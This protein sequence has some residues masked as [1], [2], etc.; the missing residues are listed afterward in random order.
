MRARLCIIGLLSAGCATSRVPQQLRGYD[1][2]VEGKD[3]QS[4]ELARVM[5]GYGFRV[6][7]KV[8]GGGRPTAALIYFTFPAAPKQSNLLHVWLADTRSGA[9]IGAGSVVLDSLTATPRARAAAVI[10]AMIAP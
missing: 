6:R 8:R 1:V 7:D 10:H 9:I 4:V 3:E 5:R 2:L